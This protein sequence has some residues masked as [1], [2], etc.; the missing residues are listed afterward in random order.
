VWNLVLIMFTKIF[1]VL[2]LT[3]N[4][5]FG[6]YSFFRRLVSVFCDID[7]ESNNLLHKE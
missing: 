5:V 2:S 7:K 1:C 4:T 3:L 6:Y